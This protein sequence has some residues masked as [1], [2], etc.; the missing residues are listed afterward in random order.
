[1]DQREY[2]AGVALIHGLGN[3]RAI[4]AGLRRG[5]Q[6]QWDEKIV[7]VSGE[8]LKRPQIQAIPLVQGG[9]TRPSAATYEQAFRELYE[10]L[11]RKYPN[12]KMK[13]IDWDKVGRELLPLAAKVKDDDEFGLLCMRLVA[14]LEDSH[15]V[16]G[17]GSVRVPRLPRVP[18]A[19]LGPGLCL[20]DRRP[21]AAGGLPHRQGRGGRESR[22]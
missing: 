21:R 18:S 19:D 12:F 15:A 9:T 4:A 7:P 1:M 10:T 3:W 17:D 11:G 8:L 5:A 20:P 13:G 6:I 14:K 2:A 16:L 22:A